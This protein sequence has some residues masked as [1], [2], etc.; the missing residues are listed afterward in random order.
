MDPLRGHDDW[1]T[2]VAFSP[3]AR[4]MVSASNDKTV[5]VWDAQTVQA[6]MDPFTA[7]CLS[8][9]LASSSPFVL[10]ITSTHSEVGNITISDFHRTYFCD[11]YDIPL[12]KFSHHH[13]K[14]IMLPDHAYLLWLPDQNKSGLFWPRTTAVIG[15]IPTSL[16]FNNFVHGINW[17]QCFS[18]L[19]DSI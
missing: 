17:S 7:S 6:I 9:C 11:F 5:R 3:D 1:I 2:S 19:C 18:S 8:T 14:W 16:Q 15:A 12:L 4:Y 10:S 13:E